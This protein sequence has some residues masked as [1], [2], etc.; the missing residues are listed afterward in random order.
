[1]SAT[2]SLLPPDV[3]GVAAHFLLTLTPLEKNFSLASNPSSVLT[4][5]NRRA[6][7]RRRAQSRESENSSDAQVD[8]TCLTVFSVEDLRRSIGVRLEVVR[9]VAATCRAARRTWLPCLNQHPLQ[10]YCCVNA[11]SPFR[12]CAS[13]L[14]AQQKSEIAAPHQRGKWFDLD[15]NAVGTCLHSAVI[16]GEAATVAAVLQHLPDL[17]NKPDTRDRTP[18]FLACC[19]P[20]ESRRRQLSFLLLDARA[21]PNAWS[22]RRGAVQAGFRLPVEG[23]EDVNK[24][25][26]LM[27]ACWRLDVDLCRGLLRASADIDNVLNGSPLAVS[28]AGFHS[29]SGEGPEPIADPERARSSIVTLLLNARAEPNGRVLDCEGQLSLP[30]SYECGRNS[31]FLAARNGSLSVLRHLID[32]GADP[33]WRDEFGDDALAV[34]SHMAMHRAGEERG[35]LLE[36]A[37]FLRGLR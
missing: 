33:H 28:L 31:C 29:H 30:T 19:L 37:S 11:L 1:M 9:N 17:V 6:R 25:T 34:A 2:F 23:W 18:L 8:R 35:R 4:L 27:E 15:R 10:I 12:Y 26:P 16:G 21:D 22:G 13:Q 20:A 7:A 14:S 5:H 3:V 24:S 32:A 36:C